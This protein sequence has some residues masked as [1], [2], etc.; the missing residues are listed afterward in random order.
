VVSPSDVTE[1]RGEKGFIDDIGE[2]CPTIS[3]RSH[4][5]VVMEVEGA[6][7]GEQ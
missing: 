2:E 3:G 7:G 4:R 6:Q 5:A 1:R